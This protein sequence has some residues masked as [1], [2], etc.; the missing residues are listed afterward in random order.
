MSDYYLV[1]GERVRWQDLIR[2]AKQYG[3]EGDGFMLLVS[4]AVEVLRENGFVV[5]NDKVESER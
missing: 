3:Y 4:E 5:E 1:N 2:L